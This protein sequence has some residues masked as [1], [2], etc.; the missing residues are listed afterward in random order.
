MKKLRQVYLLKYI[1]EYEIIIESLPEE[2][3]SEIKKYWVQKENQMG[4]QLIVDF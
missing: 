4:K 3:V 2:V 1:Q